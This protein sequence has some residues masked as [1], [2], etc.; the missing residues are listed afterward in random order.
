MSTPHQLGSV[1]PEPIPDDAYVLPE[2][3]TMGTGLRGPRFA[4]EEWDFRPFVPRTQSQVAC[5]FA[6]VHDDIAERTLREYLYSRIRRGSAGDVPH[7]RASRTL[8]ITGICGAALRAKAVLA[9]LRQ[10]GA[11]RLSEVTKQHLQDA[12]SIW[13]ARSP[14]M[15]EAHVNEL[16]HFAAHSPFLSQDRLLIAPWPGRA[17]NAVAGNIR[18]EGENTTK[19]I[20]EEISGPLV[21]GALFYV[22]HAGQDILAARRELKLLETAHACGPRRSPGETKAL[23]SAFVDQRRAEGRGIPALAWGAACRWPKIPVINGVPQ[24]PNKRM[25]GLLL[26]T[27]VAGQ[28]HHELLRRAGDELGY[29][30]GGLNTPMP[31]WPDSG[32]PWRSSLDPWNLRLELGYL[33]TACWILIAFLSGARDVEVRELRRDCAFI[34]TA[35]DGRPRYKLRG[36]VFKGRKLSGDEVEWVVLNV[37][38]QAVDILLQLND[39]PTHLFGRL[40]GENAGY[41][42]LSDVNLKL[43]RFREHLSGLFSTPN[44]LFIPRAPVT[45]GADDLDDDDL[46]TGSATGL[47]WAFETRQFR[48][49]LA[50][51]IA[52]QP[53][54]IVAGARQFHHA[55]TIM[56]EGYAGTSASGSP[57]RSR[58]RR[59]SRN[60]TTWKIFTGTG[61]TAAA[62]AA[63]RLS[64]STPSWPTSRSGTVSRGY[65]HIR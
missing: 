1:A 54:G 31:I 65:C 47:P 60:W 16:K 24:H 40:T 29:E 49:T 42:L 43:A 21:K 41:R 12:L 35:D 45:G 39:D 58:R 33:R 38:H 32:R 13:K 37:V 57:P 11:P 36:R 25:I 10:V 51:H 30:P 62:P 6:G 53:F 20:P 61:M 46:G 4:D 8:K 7:G 22:Q 44:G 14:V 15:A 27:I 19:R 2:A 64:A 50:W 9:T 59:P 56:F 52:H 26:G 55:K 23:I 48:R 3:L 63:A 17:A 28:G 18:K 34:D 5:D